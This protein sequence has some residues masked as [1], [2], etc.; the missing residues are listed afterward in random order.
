LFIQHELLFDEDQISWE[1]IGCG[2]KFMTGMQI[3][4]K[5]LAVQGLEKENS[6]KTVVL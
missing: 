1:R 4:Q 6:L 5:F 3:A 2:C